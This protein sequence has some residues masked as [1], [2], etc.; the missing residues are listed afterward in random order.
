MPDEGRI[1]K[2]TARGQV[3]FDDQL[4]HDLHYLWSLR[5]VDSGSKELVPGPRSDDPGPGFGGSLD[6]LGYCLA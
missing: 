3:G 5:R 6:D 1:V 2:T 4:V